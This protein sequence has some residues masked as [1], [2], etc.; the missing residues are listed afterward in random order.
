[1]TETI[2]MRRERDTATLTMN[3]PPL[4]VLDIDTLDTLSTYVEGVC[5]DS[6]IR[7]LKF[8]SAIGGVFSAGNDVADHTV[9]R[10]PK[11]LEVFHRIFQTVI[12]LQSIYLKQYVSLNS[13]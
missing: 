13:F 10:A 12:D 4:N 11:M 7:F 8:D 2:H 5:L 6:S 9:E 1:M 3:R